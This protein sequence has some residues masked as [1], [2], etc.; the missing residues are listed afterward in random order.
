MRLPGEDGG[1]WRPGYGLVG[2]D[3]QV[4]GNRTVR[5]VTA[6][7]CPGFGVL[8]NPRR[9]QTT[10]RAIMQKR[11]APTEPWPS[12]GAES[13][14]SQSTVSHINGNGAVTKQIIRCL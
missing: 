4:S 11:P 13:L 2:N 12:L 6:Y 14:L 10:S 3:L 7:R 9:P 8:I 5:G 1:A